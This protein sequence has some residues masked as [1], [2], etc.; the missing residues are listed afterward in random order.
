MDFLYRIKKVLF[1]ER[2]GGT[3]DWRGLTL[4]RLLR[5]L[6]GELH[7]YSFS[8]VPARLNLI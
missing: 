1:W 7:F 8:C 5:V 4:S 3:L 6:A 2:K